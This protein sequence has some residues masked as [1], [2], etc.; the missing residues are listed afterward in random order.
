MKLSGISEKWAILTDEAGFPVAV[1]N[2]NEFL[3]A[4]IREPDSPN[5]LDYCHEPIV[6]S[7]PEVTLE[8]SLSKLV[9]E[10]DRHDDRVI[11]RETIL[12]WTASSK[13]IIGG[14][15]LLGRLLHGIARR[16]PSQGSA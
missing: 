6:V 1:L 8:K 11:D 16:E 2:L 12:Y 10:S 3:R 9:V 5:P 14:P 13:R 4:V 7:D 15:D